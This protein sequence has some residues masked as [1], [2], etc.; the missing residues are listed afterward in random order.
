MVTAYGNGSTAVF[1]ANSRL[2]AISTLRERHLAAPKAPF[3]H[4][5]AKDRVPA[6]LK[7]LARSP[8]TAASGADV[9]ICNSIM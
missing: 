4:E 2:G 6:R 3:A 8:E 1:A 7:R 5:V 9:E